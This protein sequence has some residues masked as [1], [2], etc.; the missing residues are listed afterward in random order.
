[1]TSEERPID[2]LARLLGTIVVVEHAPV[3][4]RRVVT[5]L[6]DG[7]RIEQV[8]RTTHAV[9]PFG[10]AWLDVLLPEASAEGGS[11]GRPDGKPTP[12]SPLLDRILTI[13]AAILV[14]EQTALHES[15]DWSELRRERILMH[16]E[17]VRRY[18][19]SLER[20]IDRYIRDRDER[21]LLSHLAAQ[22]LEENAARLADGDQLR[23]MK[24][25]VIS[26]LAVATRSATGAG[27]NVPLAF[28]IS[29]FFIREIERADSIAALTPVL[30]RAIRALA[31]AVQ[32]SRRLGRTALVRA[33]EEWIDVHL[34]SAVR[35]AQIAA[36]LGVDAGYLASL[37]RRETGMVMDEY[38]HRR[39]VEQ[40]MTLLAHTSLSF[41]EIC[42]RLGF[43][44][45]SHFTRV[46]RRY[47]GET[48]SGYRNR[49][50]AFEPTRR[51]AV[52]DRRR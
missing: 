13:A 1:M 23:G 15:P 49:T 48:P 41:P 30:Q 35:P 5:T 40:A 6:A 46:F 22:P 51:V 52:G 4:G 20:A 24:N 27:T 10:S 2:R 36:G 32:S 8:D 7:V 50:R 12:D 45:Q 28:G 11:W 44:D 14:H 19:L 3:P 9:I 38:T 18:S 26:I 29:D 21:S 34:D 25:L 43:Y 39:K 17:A 37:F 47:A 33:A 16:D 42:R 31:D